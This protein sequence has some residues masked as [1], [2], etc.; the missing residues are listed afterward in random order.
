[1]IN[2]GVKK[3]EILTIAS[4]LL[5]HVI[6]QEDT[7]NPKAEFY[8]RLF[9][10]NS[11][12][13]D[14]KTLKRISVD[15]ISIEPIQIHH[16]DHVTGWLATPGVHASF[17]SPYP[18]SAQ[19]LAPYFGQPNRLYF[20][21][22]YRTEP[23]GFIGAENIDNR[24]LRLEMRKLVG[25]TDLRGKGIGKRATFAFLYHV[26]NI[27]EFEKIYIHSTDINMRN[28]NLNSRFGFQLEGVFL[29]ELKVGDTRRD[30]VRMGLTRSHWLRIFSQMPADAE[31][32]GSAPGDRL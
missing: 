3:P 27:L 21:I 14:W 28:L 6:Q 5:D 26:F 30:M 25:K 29:Q 11:I 9:T 17:Y 31:G 12:R 23:V 15:E 24:S 18:E 22:V 10:L 19:S 4:H 16:L 8:N 1:L 32:Q 13:D 2:Y 7:P 20:C